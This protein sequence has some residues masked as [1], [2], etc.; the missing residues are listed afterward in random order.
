MQISSLS[1]NT[2]KIIDNY[3]G[4]NLGNKKVKCPYFINSKHK[5]MDL[6]TLVGKG[7]PTEIEDEVKI[8]AQI[9]KFDLNNATEF[10]IRKFMQKYG[11]GVDCSGFVSHILN[12]ELEDRSMPHL[13]K[14]MTF[15]DQSLKAK[16]SRFFR[17]VE[18]ISANGLTN[19]LNSVKIKLMNVQPLD[20]IRLHSII[21]GG[22]HVAIVTKVVDNEIEYIH[23]SRFYL[24]ENGVRYGKIKITNPNS[25]DLSDQEWIDNDKNGK[26]WIKEEYEVN[27]E[28]SGFRRLNCF[29]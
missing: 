6:R 1:E 17:E 13:R 16:I 8:W 3:F 5:K 23:S 27:K 10:E 20:L 14:V 26:N 21:P 7:K 18:F 25:E 12:T 22:F 9:M 28:D 4:L 29:C 2:Q 11:I 24:D 19:E 15:H